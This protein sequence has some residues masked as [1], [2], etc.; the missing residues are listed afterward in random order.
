MYKSNKLTVIFSFGVWH[1]LQTIKAITISHVENL[2]LCGPQNGPLRPMMWKLRKCFTQPPFSISLKSHNNAQ[3][4]S[5]VIK[6]N[7][8]KHNG[9]NKKWK[10]VLSFIKR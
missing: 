1:Y 10:R 4:D 8:E 5:N 9:V 2:F 7:R 6:I 3:I